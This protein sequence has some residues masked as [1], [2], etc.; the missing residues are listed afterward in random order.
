LIIK[1]QLPGMTKRMKSIGNG[2][3]QLDARTQGKKR[4][5]AHH[6]FCVQILN[7]AALLST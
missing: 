7:V 6:Y 1:A 4:A 5:A 2:F 3:G